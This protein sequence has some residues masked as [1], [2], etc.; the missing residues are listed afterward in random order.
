MKQG[1]VVGGGITGV[2]VAGSLSFPCLI[3]E[4]KE[5]LG[6]LLKSYHIEGFTF[7]TDG[8]FLHF[9]NPKIKEAVLKKCGSI[10]K[11]HT[12]DS[13]IF[14]RGKIVPFPLQRHLYYI[15][16]SLSTRIFSEVI[17]QRWGRRKSKVTLEDYLFY[18]Y[19]KTLL[20][21]FFRPYFYKLYGINLSLIP[22]SEVARFFPSDRVEDILRGYISPSSSPSGYNR[23]FYYPKEGGIEE[24]FQRWREKDIP[25]IT[26]KKVIRI[27]WKRKIVEVEGGEKIPYSF[28]VYTP[29][30]VK[31]FPLLSP[32]LTSISR[33]KFF[34]NSLLC[35]NIGVKGDSSLKYQWI[36][37]P[38]K[39]FTFFR[40][41]FYS[42]V[43]SS[44]APSGHFSL[45]VEVANRVYSKSLEKRILK[46]LREVNILK[47]SHQVKV[48]F[49]VEIKYAYPFYLGERKEL[50]RIFSSLRERD[51]YP[52]GRYGKWSYYSIED[53]IQEGESVAKDIQER[54][55]V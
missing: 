38:E 37:F 23:V 46:E 21:K 55:K 40:V 36:Y 8:H 35:F 29:P 26:N 2:T 44:L 50:E 41:G 32:P 39:I 30:L 9:R 27:Y 52:A 7:D 43:S 4:E 1:I 6:G 15:P 10:L 31:L 24:F 12:R 18:R 13:V 45:Y 34:F 19:G 51:I 47:D 33:R 54:W 16:S 25:Y 17:I 3:L 49:P 28:L 5:R 11:P 22:F 48:I 14:W 42:R 53:C 20:E